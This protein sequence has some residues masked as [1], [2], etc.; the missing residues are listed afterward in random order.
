MKGNIKGRASVCERCGEHL[1]VKQLSWFTRQP[2]GLKCIAEENALKN[3]M[4]LIGLNINNFQD[5]GAEAYAKLKSQVARH[6][7][8]NNSVSN[9]TE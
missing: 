6:R 1:R 2:I 8:S 3:T 9:G 5:V 4:R 7:A